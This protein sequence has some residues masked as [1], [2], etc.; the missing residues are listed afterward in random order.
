M[1]LEK[2]L[3]LL[4]ANVILTR[5]VDEF[6]SLGGRTSLSNVKDTDAFISI[7]YNS[8]P[9]LPQVSGIGTYYYHDQHKK[10]AT[11][12]QN[13]VIQTTDA[14]DRGVAFENFHVI[15]QS[16]KPSIL[17]ELG[18][19]SNEEEENLLKRNPYQKKIVAGILHGLQ[20]YFND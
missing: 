19:L 8:T 1:E 3:K 11:E 16:F 2:E 13:G 14:N 20:R 10:L 17:I 4:G 18:F 15:R 12:I 5:S 6:I 9:D 7:H